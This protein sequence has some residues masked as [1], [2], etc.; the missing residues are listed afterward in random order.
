MSIRRAPVALGNHRRPEDLLTLRLVEPGPVT[1]IEVVGDL[2]LNTTHLLTEFAEAVLRAP[3]P[4]VMV[5]VLDL[6]RLRFFCADGIRALLHVRDTATA[7]AAQLIVRD[8]SP[9]TYRVLTITGMLDAFEIKTNLA[10][11]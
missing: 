7:H 10:N 3:P 2:D 8:P 11:A 5:L 1:V 6:S 9:I 4:T